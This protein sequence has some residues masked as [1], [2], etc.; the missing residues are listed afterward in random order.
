MNL[1]TIGFTQTTAE[2]FFHR[3]GAANVKRIIDVRLNNT[4]QLAGFAKAGDL[5]YFAKA[6]LKADYIHEPLL[7]PTA[8]ILDAYKKNGGAWDEYEKR[9]NDLMGRRKIDE[10][11]D[12]AIFDGACLLCSEDKPHH[13]HRRLV[14]EFLKERWRQPVEIR[15]L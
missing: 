1:Y 2:R 14:A 3:L 6:I 10:K 12:P 9:F 15:H 8:D 4:S 13:C 7:A 11:L 5:A